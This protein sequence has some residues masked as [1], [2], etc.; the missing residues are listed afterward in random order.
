MSSTVMSNL[1]QSILTHPWQRLLDDA[2]QHFL[3][4]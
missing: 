4:P 2:L 3:K 1:P